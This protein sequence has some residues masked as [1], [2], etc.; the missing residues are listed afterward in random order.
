RRRTSATTAPRRR[1]TVG[2]PDQVGRVWDLSGARPRQVFP[3]GP[4]DPWLY[5]RVT[6]A[7]DGKSLAAWRHRTEPDAQ[8]KGE[9]E[10]WH[11]TAK[12]PQ[13][14]AAFVLNDK[15][16]DEMSFSADGRTLATCGYSEGN[17]VRLWDTEG[18]APSYQARVKLKGNCGVY[19]FGP[20]G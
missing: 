17:I 15:A 20:A 11:L 5:A 16:P 14:R 9:M 6:F 10:L 1:A 12:A 7:P 18:A 2:R 13:R 3:E 19:R 8:A 4:E